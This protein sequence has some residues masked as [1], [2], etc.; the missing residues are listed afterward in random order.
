MTIERKTVVDQ[1]EICRN[2][3][4][5]IRLG[6]LLV[7]DGAEID[8]KYHR[9]VL[10]PGTTAIDQ[11]AVVNAHL[12]AVGKNPVSDEDIASIEDARE[13]FGTAMQSMQE[14]AVAQ[15]DIKV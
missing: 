5:N 9:T 12:S 6:L 7:E 10:E 4:I 2:G 8:C 15:T 13:R 14:E 1:I 11:F 3:S